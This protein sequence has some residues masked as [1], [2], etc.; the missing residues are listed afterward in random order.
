MPPS[1][2]AAERWLAQREVN[3]RARRRLF[4]FPHA[5]GGASAFRGW[6]A[7][8]P[9]DVEVCPVQPPGRENRLEER[10]FRELQP[11]VEAAADALQPLF[12]LPFAFYGHGMGAAIAYGLACELRRRGRALPEALFVAG[13][14]APEVPL[15][16]A[17]LH[18]LPDAELIAALL[19]RRLVP[20][21][22]LRHE[23][24]MQLLLPVLR[25]DLTLDETTSF[26]DEQK[27]PL[28]LSAFV[29]TKDDSLALADVEPWA[30]RIV[31]TFRLHE[32]PGD[33]F[34]VHS[35]RRPL[36]EA[37]ARDLA[38]LPPRS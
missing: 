36:L 28:A 32:L 31:G 35:S 1:P 37:I 13:R 6:A 18:D 5:G 9:A 29:G 4:C 30:E 20:E 3:P 22:V 11:L 21:E 2:P 12:S 14:R 27:F 38:Q 17:P 16:S 26:A 25:A 34:F 15:R 7:E 24:L 23:E 10:A 19:E 8:L 33:Q